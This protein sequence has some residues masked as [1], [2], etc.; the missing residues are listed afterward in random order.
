MIFT[1][2]ISRNVATKASD[3]PAIPDLNLEVITLEFNASQSK[4]QQICDESDKDPQ[5]VLLKKLIIQGRPRDIRE[6]PLPIVSHGWH[7]G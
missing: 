4:L 5:L 3:V 6:C 2:N 1:D 7:H